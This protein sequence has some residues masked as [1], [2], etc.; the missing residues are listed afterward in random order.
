[1]T[2]KELL[3][4]IQRFSETQLDSDVCIYDTF[5]DEHYQLNVELVFAAETDVLDIDHP[6]IRF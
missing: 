1:M 3:A 5:T 2:Y 4:Q 6:V